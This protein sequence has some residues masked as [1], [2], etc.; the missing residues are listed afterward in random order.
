MGCYE[1]P[2][3]TPGLAAEEEHVLIAVRKIRIAKTAL[4]GGEKQSM[5]FGSVR[6]V[7]FHEIIKGRVDLH[8]DVRP[9]IQAG[10]LKGLVIDGEAQRLH[11]VKHGIRGRAGAGDVSGV[12]RDLRLYEDYM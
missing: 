5:R 7:F 3:Q 1:I 9:V 4:G 6:A 11:Q 2:G 8:F 12:G 10:A